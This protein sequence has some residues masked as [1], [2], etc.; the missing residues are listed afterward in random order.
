MPQMIFLNGLF[1]YLCFLIIYKWIDGSTADLYTVLIDMFLS[2]GSIDED[3]DLYGGQSTVQVILVLAAFFSV[4]WMLLP[5][6]FI[7]RA[8]HNRRKLV[9]Q[10]II[11]FLVVYLCFFPFHPFILILGWK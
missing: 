6:P 1:G 10:Q 2:P 9:S 7:L 8:R 11:L 4:P 3:G 5:K